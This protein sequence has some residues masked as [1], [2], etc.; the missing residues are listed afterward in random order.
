MTH[1]STYKHVFTGVPISHT[2]ITINFTV[3]IYHG[4]WI[5]L[6]L[7]ILAAWW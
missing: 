4:N 3:E 6:L 2:C 7:A 5:A 1:G